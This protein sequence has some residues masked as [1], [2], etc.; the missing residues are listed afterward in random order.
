MAVVI[1]WAGCH[2]RK[3]VPG[4]GALKISNNGDSSVGLDAEQEAVAGKSI[5]L[6]G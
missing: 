5:H 6:E 1:Q 4:R 2:N 3:S